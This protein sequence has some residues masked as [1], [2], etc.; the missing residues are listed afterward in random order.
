MADKNV[1]PTDRQERAGRPRPY[2]KADRNVRPTK[3]SVSPVSFRPEGFVHDG[4]EFV[5]G[6]ADGGGV[7]ELGDATGEIKELFFLLRVDP[8]I[9]FLGFGVGV[10]GVAGLGETLA[11]GLDGLV[12]FVGGV[13]DFGGGGFEGLLLGSTGGRR[14]A[15]ESG[16]SAALGVA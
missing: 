5:G 12:A 9:V 2:K 15:G 3:N 1:L 6:F 7:V 10:M 14:S 8:E 13:G 16:G 4:V 11:N